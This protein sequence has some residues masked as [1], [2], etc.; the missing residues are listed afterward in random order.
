[1]LCAGFGSAISRPHQAV[2]FITCRTQLLRLPNQGPAPISAEFWGSGGRRRQVSDR[3]WLK[4]DRAHQP[5][6]GAERCTQLC[7]ALAG[8]L[9]II[10]FGRIITTVLRAYA[11]PSD[12]HCGGAPG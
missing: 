8:P 2:A 7:P 4:A 10:C 1:M 11:S 5:H 6:D 9:A 12:C 3:L